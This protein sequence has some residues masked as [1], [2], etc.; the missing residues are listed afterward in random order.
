MADYRE[1][2]IEFY[3]NDKRATFS[4]TQGRFKTRIEKLAEQYPD[5]CEICAKN[6]DGSWYGHIPTKWIR[7]QPNTGR[8]MTEEEKQASAERLAKYRKQK[9]G[10]QSTGG[11]I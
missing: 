1:N 6:P 8:E 4:F 7:I 2:A 11:A 3:E 5:E 9:K 10:K